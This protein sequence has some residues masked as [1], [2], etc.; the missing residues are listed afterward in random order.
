M[1]NSGSLVKTNTYVSLIT[2]DNWLGPFT[3]NRVR[4]LGMRIVNHIGVTN[5]VITTEPNVSKLL[6]NTKVIVHFKHKGL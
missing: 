1:F 3:K 4:Q 6:E 5:A 2:W